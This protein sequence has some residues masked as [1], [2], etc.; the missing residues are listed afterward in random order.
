M[1]THYRH[2]PASAAIF[3][4][5]V[6]DLDHHTA[7]GYIRENVTKNGDNVDCKI[8]LKSEHMKHYHQINATGT[9]SQG[10]I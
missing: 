10:C 7:C 8:C 3:G 9:D 6:V 2:V 5:G 4:E 1:K